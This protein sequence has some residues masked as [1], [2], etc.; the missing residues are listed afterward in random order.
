MFGGEEVARADTMPNERRNSPTP[1]LARCISKPPDR[2]TLPRDRRTRQIKKSGVRYGGISAWD[3]RGGASI[4]AVLSR[5]DGAGEVL[6]GGFV[7]YTKALKASALGVSADLPREKSAVVANIQTS[8]GLLVQGRVNSIPATAS[9]PR[10]S[11]QGSASASL[12]LR[13]RLPQA[14][15]PIS[16]L[17]CAASEHRF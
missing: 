13:W 9:T 17:P 14:R 11:P 10:L 16:A 15:T 8:V 12:D 3:S 4:A 7:T 1:S 2:R 5:A 6:H